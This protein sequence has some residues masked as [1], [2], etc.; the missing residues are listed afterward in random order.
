[1]SAG[2]AVERWIRPSVVAGAWYPDD[3]ELLAETVD[4]YLQ[5]VRPVDGDP[6]ALIVPHAGYRYS[7]TVAAY[8]FR[9][10]EGR[11]ID[12]VVILASD[13]QPPLSR[14]VSIWSRGGFDTPLG[15][16]PVNEQLAGRL[17]ESHPDIRFDPETH[18][19][20]HP[21]EI[22]LPFLKRVCPDCQ[23]LPIQIG[24]TD[25]AVVDL[26]VQSLDKILP[27]QGVVIVASSDLAHYPAYQDALRIDRSTLGAIERSD[28]EFFRETVRESMRSKIRN[29]ATCA[30]GEAPI[31]VAM[32]IARARGAD[33]SSVLHYSN[34]GEVEH[35]DRSRVVGYGA[36]MFWRYEPPQLDEAQKHRLLEMARQAVEQHT[37]S[38]SLPVEPVQDPGLNRLSAVF[39]TLRRAGELRGCIGQ[40]VAD[41]PL[42]QAVREK[43][44][45]AGSGD[46]RFPPLQR[47]E[48]DGLSYSIA[49]LSPLRR[50][51]SPDEIEIGRHGVSIRQGANRSVLLPQVAADRS[52]T[53]RQLLENLCQKAGLPPDS[54]KGEAALYRF[55]TT[56]IEE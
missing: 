43:A 47:G 16:M 30:C 42:Y 8:G 41:T 32:E 23:I 52:W 13:H 3:P 19:A 12:T 1:M 48:L 22:E 24:S 33:V 6:L 17:V 26:L 45:A 10:L 55:T 9:Q 20:E 14:P 49:I 51:A 27:R 15:V 29:L 53:R 28:A 37:L 34:S 18:M 36:V 11:Q 50:T 38:G 2:P 35:G 46:P 4:D 21:I 56:E 40:V 31:L 54:W 44:V 39:V 5:A 25:P 7:G